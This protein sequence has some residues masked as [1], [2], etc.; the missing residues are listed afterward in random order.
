MQPWAT[1][2]SAESAMGAAIRFNY[3]GETDDPCL[4]ILYSFLHC[5]PFTEIGVNKKEADFVFFLLT[6]DDSGQKG[7]QCLQ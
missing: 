4:N 6:G 7:L 3:G 5:F 1:A 2:A